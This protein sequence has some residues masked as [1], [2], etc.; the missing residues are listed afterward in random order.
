LGLE[1]RRVR[2]AAEFE[3]LAE[4]RYR[5]YVEELG[6]LDAS[7]ADPGRRLVDALDDAS[8]SYAVFDGE[9]VVGSLRMTHLPDVSDPE[10]LVRKFRYGDAISEFGASAICMTSRFIVDEQVRRGRAMLRMMELCYEDGAELGVRLNYGDTSPGLLL[11]YEHMGYRRYTRPWNDE[12]YGFK[13]P[14][15]MLGRDQEWFRRAR[16]PLLRVSRREAH[17][18][19]AREWFEAT[20][21]A[22]VE[23]ESAPFQGV[24]AFVAGVERLLGGSPAEL[25]GLLQG[26]SR[27]ELEA[28]LAR[29]SLFD[30]CE[31]DRVVRPGEREH[32]LLVVASGR[33]TEK[34]PNGSSE[35]LTAGAVFGDFA[36]RFVCRQGSEVVASTASRLLVLPTAQLE[37]VLAAEDDRLERLRA[38]L[39]ALVSGRSVV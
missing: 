4:Y 32:A 24:A 35:S 6:L 31:G 10:P 33:L 30:A 23:C 1:V 8:T 22:F 11:F 13:L 18:A 20:H 38:R 2:S 15:V 12:V 36:G 27:E 21:G 16:S 5:V 28:L 34:A 25:P 29:A 14:I 9:R 39:A 26:L 3:R 7:A 19:E 17:D 37:H